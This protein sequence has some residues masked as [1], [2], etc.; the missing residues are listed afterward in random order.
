MNANSAAR[1]V[2]FGLGATGTR[3]AQRLVADSRVASV[4]VRE[5][6]SERLRVAKRVL[7]TDVVSLQ[8]SHIPP[9][10]DVVVAA[11]NSGTQAEIARRALRAGSHVVTTS[12]DIAETRDLLS[13]DSL[14]R[15]QGATLVVGAGFMPGLTCLLARLGSAEL[16][17]VDEVHVAKV[18]TGGP[19]CARQHH[20]ALSSLAIDWRDG[21]WA[22]RAGGSG[23]ELCWFPD[24]V[25]GHDC[26]RAALPDALLLVPAFADVDRVTARM[27]ATRRDRATA[28]LPM[29]RKPHPEG[30]LGAVRVELRGW[31]GDEHRVVVFGAKALPALGASIVANCTVL[32]LLEGCAVPGAAGLASIDRPAKLLRAVRDQGLNCYRFEGFGLQH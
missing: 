2:V 32:H 20:H 28:P 6:D 29:M 1:V 16:D 7:G 3:I 17:H 10:T 15:K 14:A 8:G 27:A 24:P 31:R 19:G 12:D 30:R 23:R 22:R 5:T 25:G 18:G 13:F 9:N 21:R 4:H 26:Y 11:T